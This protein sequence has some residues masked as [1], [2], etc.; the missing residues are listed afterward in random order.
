MVM[1]A[2]LPPAARRVEANSL[3][4]KEYIPYHLTSLPEQHSMAAR[5]A[6]L[7]SKNQL[8]LPKAAVAALGNPTHFRVQVHEGV[9]LLWPG[10]LLCTA[11]MAAPAD[12]EQASRETPKG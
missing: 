4:D 2:A 11:D 9:L 6:K 7:T 8:T 12:A 3:D 10:R 1:R 5:L